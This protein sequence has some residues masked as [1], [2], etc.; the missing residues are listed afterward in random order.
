[1][2]GDGVRGGGGS[3]QCACWRHRQPV[4][5]AATP[6]LPAFWRFRARLALRYR[7]AFSG[8][9]R[10][11]KAAAPPPASLARP[12]MGGSPRGPRWPRCDVRPPW[13][14]VGSPCH[15]PAGPAPRHPPRWSSACRRMPPHRPAPAG[16]SSQTRA[17]P[18]V[19][20]PTAAGCR[21]ESPEPVRQRD[22]AFNQEPLVEGPNQD[23]PGKDNIG[24]HNYSGIVGTVGGVDEYPLMNPSDDTLPVSTM[25]LIEP[26]LVSV[27]SIIISASCTFGFGCCCLLLCCLLFFT[28]GCFS[29]VTS[30]CSSF[31]S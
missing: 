26:W 20:R 12:P 2:T 3:G 9:L 23:Q 13:F 5:P 21:H 29:G 30:F 10:D 27:S 16:Q 14:P 11:T 19:P 17:N 24:D 18:P 15:A 7:A 25:N 22:A 6:F 4:W 8:T 28:S 1:M 31:I